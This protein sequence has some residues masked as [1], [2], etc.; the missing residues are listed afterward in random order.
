ME[1]QTTKYRG[2]LQGVSNNQGAYLGVDQIKPVN[3]SIENLI[4][5][6]L[7][8]SGNNPSTE[9]KALDGIATVTLRELGNRS[10]TIQVQDSHIRHL[11]GQLVGAYRDNNELTDNRNHWR[12]LQSQTL[13]R[14]ELAECHLDR[15]MGF[16]LKPD[17]DRVPYA[18]VPLAVASFMVANGQKG[19]QDQLLAAMRYIDGI[20]KPSPEK[21][22]DDA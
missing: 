21:G 18:D 15:I 16:L 12:L 13:R 11:D 3:D 20:S 2:V 17:A 10:R 9:Q 6:S 5:C 8:Y 14:A 19:P 22:N 1:R 4:G 7:A